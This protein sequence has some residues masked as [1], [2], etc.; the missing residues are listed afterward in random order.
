V[1]AK[2]AELVGSSS[3]GAVCMV[4]GETAAF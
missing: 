4:P 2:Y 1:F 3:K